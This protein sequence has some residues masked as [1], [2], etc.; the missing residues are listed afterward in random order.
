MSHM[1]TSLMSTKLYFYFSV[2]SELHILRKELFNNWYK[3]STYFVAFLVTNMPLQ[4]GQWKITK[5][6]LRNPFPSLITYIYFCLD[7]V[8]FYLYID[9]LLLVSTTDD[10]DQILDVLICLSVN[11]PNI[12][13]YWP[14]SRDSYEPSCKSIP[15][16]NYV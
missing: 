13:R 16:V 4:V 8:L 14:Y 11:D 5:T 10:V 3:L 15:S 2:P 7:D 9:F 12:W 6:L 1:G